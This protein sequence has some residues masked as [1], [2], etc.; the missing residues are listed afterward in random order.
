MFKVKMECAPNIMKGIFE[1]GNQNY[2]FQNNF[3]I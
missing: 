3:L 1:T 2:N